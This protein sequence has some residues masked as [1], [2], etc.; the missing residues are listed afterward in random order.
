MNRINFHWIQ[1]AQY[2]QRSFLLFLKQ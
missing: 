2:I 1:N